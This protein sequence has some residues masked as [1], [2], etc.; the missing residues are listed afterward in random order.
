MKNL[1]TKIKE[2]REQKFKKLNNRHFACYAGFFGRRIED[3]ISVFWIYLAKKM[4]NI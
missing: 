2:E 4:E 1:S 3:K